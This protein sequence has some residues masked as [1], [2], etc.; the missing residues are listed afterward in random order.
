M[1]FKLIHISFSFFSFTIL[2]YNDFIK[3]ISFDSFKHSSK[4]TIALSLSTSS[5]GTHRYDFSKTSYFL[6]IQIY[7][8]IYDI[9]PDLIAVKLCDLIP[10]RPIPTGCSRTTPELVYFILKVTRRA[11]ISCHIAVVALI[12]F[13][14]CKKALPKNA[15]GDQGNDYYMI[16]NSTTIL[17][18]LYY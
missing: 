3:T 1:C 15:I 13:D 8:Y 14:R 6:Y 5:I 17:I 2:K 18:L 12:Y 4:N 7:L 9:K 11:R 10:T 16:N